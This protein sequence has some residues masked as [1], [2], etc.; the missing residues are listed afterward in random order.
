MNKIKALIMI[1]IFSNSLLFGIISSI[2]D[3]NTGGYSNQVEDNAKI[4]VGIESITKEGD[5]YTI[6]VYAIN[7][8]DEIAGIQ[9][10]ILNEEL[11][12]IDS[13]YGGKTEETDFSMHFNKKGTV[14]GFS[15]V[16]ETIKRTSTVSHADKEKKNILFYAKAKSN[17]LKKF[18]NDKLMM[19]IVIA[20]KNGKTLTSKF[21]PFEL[22]E[23]IIK[24]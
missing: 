2:L 8:F 12:F 4:E 11:F 22:S 15:M 6:A 13:I 10:K 23:I 3:G 19:D 7:P 5:D 9:F 24:N 1:F 21:V 18:L 17:N 20:S 16:G 14:L